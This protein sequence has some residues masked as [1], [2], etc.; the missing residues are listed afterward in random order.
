VWMSGLWPDANG[1]VVSS[2]T[3]EVRNHA[4]QA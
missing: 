4:T 3:K 2:P 1:D